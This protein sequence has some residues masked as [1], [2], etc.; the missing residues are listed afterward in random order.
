MHRK[1]VLNFL[2]R[3]NACFKHGPA[4]QVTVDVMTSTG[5]REIHYQNTIV[6]K[7]IIN[8]T[9]TIKTLIGYTMCYKTNIINFKYI[10]KLINGQ[11]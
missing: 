1:S 6:L 5:L 4:L 3:R 2:N 8:L 7:R 9:N 11:A 10:K